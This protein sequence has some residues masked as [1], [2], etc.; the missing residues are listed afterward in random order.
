EPESAIVFCNTKRFTEIVAKRLR[1]NGIECEFIIGDLPQVKRLKIIDDIKAGHNRFL[2]ATD[3]AA[4]GLDIED[5]ALV[6]NYDLPVESENYVHRIGRTARAGKTGKALTLASEQDVYELPDIEKYIGKKIPSQIADESLFGTDKSEGIRI[7]TDFYD[8][9]EN[10]TRPG[11]TD[12]RNHRSKNPGGREQSQDL[13][14]LSFEERMA[15]YK[16]K[17]NRG[18]HI[19]TKSAGSGRSRN[20]RRGKP[21]KAGNHSHSMPDP[22]PVS[23]AEQMNVKQAS[24]PVVKQLP[25]QGILGKLAGIFGKK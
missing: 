14:E 10:K 7:R 4:R 17:Y 9:R 3:V 19:P 11:H 23:A 8:D 16:E 22:A 2:V 12:R 24:L 5:L 1:I 15:Y 6:V 18:K 13:S 21:T 20:K 25:K